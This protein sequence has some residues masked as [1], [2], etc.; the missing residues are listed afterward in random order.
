MAE[1]SDVLEE[2]KRINPFN[3]T[4]EFKGIRVLNEVKKEKLKRHHLMQEDL[5]EKDGKT[6]AV[7]CEL[8]P[9]EKHATFH[10]TYQQLASGY[11]D[12]RPLIKFL[13]ENGWIY[14]LD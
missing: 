2:V 1:L 12:L 9:E 6:Y 3:S 7:V 11:E 4:V 10:G 5:I 14:T 13:D 8:F